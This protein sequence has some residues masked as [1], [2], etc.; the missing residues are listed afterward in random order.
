MCFSRH[1]EEG[2]DE[3]ICEYVITRHRRCRG[4]L[5]VEQHEIAT[6]VYT[7]SQ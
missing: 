2:N 7:R 5:A 6:L 3:A 4:D 1:C